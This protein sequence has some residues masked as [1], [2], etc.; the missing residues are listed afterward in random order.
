MARLVP[1]V[2][3]EKMDREDPETK[4]GPVEWVPA[5]GRKIYKGPVAA[6]RVVTR[7]A[8]PR[9]H[10]IRTA[11]SVLPL[12]RVAPAAVRVVSK[13]DLPRKADLEGT[14]DRRQDRREDKEVRV[15]TRR[16][17]HRVARMARVETTAADRV[18]MA[19]DKEDKAVT[20]RDRLLLRRVVLAEITVAGKGRIAAIERILTPRGLYGVRRQ[21]DLSIPYT[22]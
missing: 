10:A 2:W 22:S 12:L 1:S 6:A 15:A 16:G 21:L 17:R 14:V 13:W 8:H 20:R 4:G 11:K 3:G 19:A 9:R 5:V 7:R 18:Q